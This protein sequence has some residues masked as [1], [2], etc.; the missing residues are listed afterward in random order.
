MDD[1]PASA[2]LAR[3]TKNQPVQIERTE[4]HSQ[5]RHFDGTLQLLDIMP[6]I[7]YERTSLAALASSEAATTRHERPTGTD[8]SRATWLEV[9]RPD[10]VFFKPA[11]SLFVRRSPDTAGSFSQVQP[12][13]PP[14]PDVAHKRRHLGVVGACN[15]GPST[16]HRPHLPFSSPL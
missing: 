1:F 11:P 8:E 13:V 6:T 9:T 5:K 7:G 16:L 3:Q 14:L 10:H 4:L 15:T 2:L 12:A